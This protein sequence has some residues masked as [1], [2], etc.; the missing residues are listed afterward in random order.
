MVLTRSRSNNEDHASPAEVALAVAALGDADFARL[1]QIARLRARGLVGVDWQDLLHDAVQRAMDGTRRW[2]SHVPFTVFLREIIRSLASEAWRRQVREKRPA[3]DAGDDNEALH[4]VPGD[5]P[6]PEC[7]AIE[8]DLV[9]RV[10]TLFADDMVAFE[11]LK[12]L[13]D[14]LSP[15]EIQ[16]R[17]GITSVEYDSTRRRIRRKIATSPAIG[18]L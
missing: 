13:A 2:P 10:E 18:D 6:D 8:Q 1:G 3:F 9:R 15:K 4:Q 14:E 16:E 11:L 5:L 12:A 7:L 17:L